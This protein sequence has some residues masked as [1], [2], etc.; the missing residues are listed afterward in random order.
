VGTGVSH[1]RR[2]LFIK[3][4]LW[5]VL[6]SLAAKDG[7]GHTYDALF[8]FD[9]A[10]TPDAAGL[11]VFSANADAPNLAIAARPDPG[12]SLSI[13]EGQQDPVQG[14][15]PAS[16]I[17]AV[18][19][20]PVAIFTQKGADTHMLYVIA[21]ARAGKQNPVAAVEPVAG[22]PLAAH[23][24]LTDG[25]VFDVAFAADGPADLSIAGASG[26]GRA[27]VVEKLA[28]GQPGR[29]LTVAP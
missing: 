20:A 25:R 7:K 6:D 28:D 24:R 21:P 14:W 1:T 16:G 13:I 15:L 22:N 2:V 8:H 23:I 10:V 18:R 19:P 26:K 4:D 9:A 17:S 12:L 29:K 3:P 5:V 11:K 27:L